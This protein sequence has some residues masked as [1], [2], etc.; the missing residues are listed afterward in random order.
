MDYDNI[1]TA[2]ELAVFCREIAPEAR[3][4]VDTEF[5][6][7]SSYRAELCLVQVCAGERLAV[8]DPLGIPDMRPFWEMLVDG[9]HITIVHAGRSEMEFCL[10]SVER[11]PKN[12]LTCR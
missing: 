8:I 6:S 5:V 7:E 4:A 9:D 12:F 3:I 1:T 2:E 10:R 11:L